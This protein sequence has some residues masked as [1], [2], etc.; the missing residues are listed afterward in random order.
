LDGKNIASKYETT[1][2]ASFKFNDK[3]LKCYTVE[4][5]NTNYLNELG[6]FTSKFYFN[7]KYGLVR[8]EYTT[9]WKDS[10]VANLKKVSF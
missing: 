3:Y 4:G 8:M 7:E 1:G 6:K 10:I 9:P 5:E 2:T